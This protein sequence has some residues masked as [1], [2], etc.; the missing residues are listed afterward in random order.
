MNA[1]LWELLQLQPGASDE[2]AFTV[3]EEMNLMIFPCHEQI[4]E[5]R[6]AIKEE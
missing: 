6:R 2:Q 3:Y 1:A 4:R 5:G